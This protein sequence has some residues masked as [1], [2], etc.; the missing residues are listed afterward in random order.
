MTLR[1]V[2]VTA[3]ERRGCPT[4]VVKSRVGSQ[5]DDRGSFATPFV[6]PRAP[7]ALLPPKEP[8]QNRPTVLKASDQGISTVGQRPHL[9]PQ[10]L[11]TWGLN[12]AERGLTGRVEDRLSPS[13]DSP[14]FLAFPLHLGPEPV[15]D[16]TGLRAPALGRATSD[17]HLHGPRMGRGPHGGRV[18]SPTSRDPPAALRPG[19][20]SLP[21]RPC[22]RPRPEQCTSPRAPARPAP[23]RGPRNFRALGSPLH[24]DTGVRVRARC[25]LCTSRG[26]AT[27]RP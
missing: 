13:P 1:V 23:A 19:P 8:R 12:R 6:W 2:C 24:G 10:A 18:W 25:R 22:P 11:L 3:V 16:R 21:P 15:G 17:P 5:T 7:F 4:E 20:T 9:L 14:L 26:R 27:S